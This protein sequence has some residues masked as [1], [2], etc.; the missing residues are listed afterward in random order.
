MKTSATVIVSRDG[1][2][3]AMRAQIK[4]F[5]YHKTAS[6]IKTKHE[7]T[8]CNAEADDCVWLLCKLR[9][10]FAAELGVMPGAHYYID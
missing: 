5:G 9:R 7:A 1:K 4:L 3:R 8:Q 2:L 10:D 6:A